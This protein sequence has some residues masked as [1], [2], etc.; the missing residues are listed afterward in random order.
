VHFGDKAIFDFTPQTAATDGFVY[1]TVYA[2]TEV[3]L[4]GI[5]NGEVVCI[6]SHEN[7]DLMVGASC[8]FPVKAGQSWAWNV[9]CHGGTDLAK[10]DHLS[11]VSWM[12]LVT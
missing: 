2:S 1:A 10:C 11:S 9:L 8:T 3:F 7:P 12:P 6:D 5:V 4:M